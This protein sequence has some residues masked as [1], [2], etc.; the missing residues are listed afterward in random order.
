LDTSLVEN[1][2]FYGLV[3]PQMYGEVAVGGVKVKAGRFISPVGY[4][5]VDTTLNFFNT[6]P[7][8]YQ[9]GEPFTH[10]GIVASWNMGE[11]LAL[12]S[13][14]IRGWDNWNSQNDF[15][16]PGVGFLGTATYTFDSG[17]SVALVF[18]Y[19]NEATQDVLVPGAKNFAPR[20][21]QTFVYQQPIGEKF[22]YI[23]QSDFGNQDDAIAGTRKSAQWYGVNQYLI[24]QQSDTL[25]WGVNFE[26]FQDDDGFRVGGFLPLSAASSYRGLPTTRLGYEG[27]FF[28]MT[29]G[30]KWQPHPN[31]FVRPNLRFDFFAGNNN[32]ADNLSPFNDGSKDWQGILATDIV[33][34]F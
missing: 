5:T 33:V 30:P 3:L 19:S 11:N 22:N 34:K 15:A 12:S 14:V 29:M 2:A 8:T 10:T 20:Y 7:Y 16:T 31:L 4:F 18:V 6:I 23:F 21:F 24:Y 26:W 27:S 13:G 32:N 1:E 17:A 28:Q 25:S 9:Y